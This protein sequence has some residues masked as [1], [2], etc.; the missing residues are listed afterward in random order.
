MLALQSTLHQQV[1]SMLLLHCAF[2]GDFFGVVPS[3]S[4]CIHTQYSDTECVRV[5]LYYQTPDNCVASW[6]VAFS[7]RHSSVKTKMTEKQRKRVK[8]LDLLP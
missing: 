8:T 3:F 2:R 7:Y 1:I 6:R 5:R 4:L